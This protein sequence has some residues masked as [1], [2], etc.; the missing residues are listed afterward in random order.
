MARRP[1]G[2][3]G[4]Q[5]IDVAHDVSGHSLGRPWLTQ[6]R[7]CFNSGARP[8]LARDISRPPIATPSYNLSQR[9]TAISIFEKLRISHLGKIAEKEFVAAGVI[10]LFNPCSVPCSFPVRSLLRISSVLQKNLKMPM[11]SRFLNACR[12]KRQHFPCIFP[13]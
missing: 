1:P 11:E 2:K 13:C 7:K 8:I 9:A 4:T 5:V 12:K 3:L 10:S 6:P